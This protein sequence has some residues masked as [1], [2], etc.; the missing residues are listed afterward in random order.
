MSINLFIKILI[1]IIFFNSQ[2]TLASDIIMA[3]S[4]DLKEFDQLISKEPPPSKNS[5]QQLMPNQNPQNKKK[6]NN[7]TPSN[8]PGAAYDPRKEFKQRDNNSDGKSGDDR[9]K[10]KGPD[11]RRGGKDDERG[12]KDDERG[13]NQPPVPG[14]QPPPPPHHN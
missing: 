8:T 11:Q 14:G 13:G 3:T 6:K 7:S 4:E 2:I 9:P 12:G 5:P 10:N 1:V